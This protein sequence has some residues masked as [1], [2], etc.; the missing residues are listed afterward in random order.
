[1][2]R[3]HSQCETSGR[4]RQCGTVL[5]WPSGVSTRVRPGGLRVGLSW[6]LLG[7]PAG[8]HPAQDNRGR[9]ERRGGK[10]QSE[11]PCCAAHRREPG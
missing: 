6:V 11:R 1:M 3:P 10:H 8:R 7:A 5:A 4:L 9:G 2:A